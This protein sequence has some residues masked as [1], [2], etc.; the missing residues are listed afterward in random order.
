MCYKEMHN[1][2]ECATKKR[3]IKDECA[4]AM[5]EFQAMRYELAKNFTH[6]YIIK[7][8]LFNTRGFGI[9]S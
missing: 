5:R 7:L 4:I 2:T 3:T 8:T 1:L 9:I 6:L